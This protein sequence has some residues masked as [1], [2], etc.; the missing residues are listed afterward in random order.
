M[1]KQLSII[2][3]K[4]KAELNGGLRLL[5][6]LF[7]QVPLTI[8]TTFHTKSAACCQTLDLVLVPLLP[9]GA[10]LCT[11]C[12]AVDKHAGCVFCSLSTHFTFLL[13]ET[14]EAWALFTLAEQW[15]SFFSTYFRAVHPI[16]HKNP[17]SRGEGYKLT[18]QACRKA[19]QPLSYYLVC[20]WQLKWQL[21][22][23][24]W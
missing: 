24:L 2:H 12:F 7:G 14:S 20:R 17:T 13:Q 22:L 23:L 11:L 16:S 3:R 8:K 15:P 5:T 9:L 18:L 4:A 19:G 6:V 1:W 21:K 10:F